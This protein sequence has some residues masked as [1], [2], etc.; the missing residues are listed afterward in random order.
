MP[1]EENNEEIEI[2]FT[3]GFIYG[4][5]D[6]WPNKPFLLAISAEKQVFLRS[7]QEQLTTEGDDMI[8]QHDRFI[9]PSRS[10]VHVF[11]FIGR[12][13]KI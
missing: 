10:T 2:H 13:M 11:D 12:K 8:E 4:T 6:K 7:N 1:I 3:N 5:D 9:D